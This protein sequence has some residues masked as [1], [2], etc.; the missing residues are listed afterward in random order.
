MIR[1]FKIGDHLDLEPNEHSRIG[2]VSDV[3]FDDTFSKHTLDD[4]GN[5]KCIMCWKQYLPKHYAVFF[6]MSDGVEPKHAKALKR[7]IN[8][9]ISEIKPKSCVTYSFDCGMLNKWHKFFGFKQ[10]RRSLLEQA[11]GFNTWLIKWV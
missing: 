7:F 11:N 3:F 9:K 10:Q 8:K 2:D 4:D 6:L 5:I 1:D